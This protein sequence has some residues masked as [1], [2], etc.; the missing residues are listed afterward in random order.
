MDVVEY[1]K[2]IKE[3]D[4]LA[5]QYDEQIDELQEKTRKCW[6]EKSALTRQYNVERLSNLKLEN[7]NVVVGIA[8]NKDYHFTMIQGIVLLNAKNPYHMETLIHK[9][10]CDDFEY[11]FSVVDHN[12]NIEQIIDMF[13]EFNTYV[14]S[15]EDYTELLNTMTMLK[16]N[17]DNIDDVNATYAKKAMRTLNE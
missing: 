9:Y 10:R 16:I 2:R 5:N 17:V 6:M 14:L 13:E 11:S 12:M 8:K 7:G 1:N 15:F 4:D 3:L